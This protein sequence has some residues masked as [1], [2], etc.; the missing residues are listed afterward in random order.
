MP[1]ISENQ[2]DNAGPIGYEMV[3]YCWHKEKQEKQGDHEE[4]LWCHSNR[5]WGDTQAAY[6]PVGIKHVFTYFFFLE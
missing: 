3:P 1:S 6:R 4:L 2:G 5:E